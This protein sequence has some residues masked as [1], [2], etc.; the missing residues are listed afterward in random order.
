MAHFRDAAPGHRHAQACPQD[1]KPSARFA[2]S[3]S[4]GRNPGLAARPDAGDSRESRPAGPGKADGQPRKG[5]QQMADA[6]SLGGLAREYRGAARRAYGS[7][8][9]TDVFSTT[10]QDPDGFHAADSFRRD[11]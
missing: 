11:V 6:V 5:R 1:L 9:H 2:L 3:P 7:D 10:V 8:G 4:P